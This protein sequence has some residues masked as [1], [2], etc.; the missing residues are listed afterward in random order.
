MDVFRAGYELA[1]L[2]E[3]V[4]GI[5]DGVDAIV[6]PSV[7]TVFTVEEVVAE[8]LASNATLGRYTDFV[9]TQ[10]PTGIPLAAA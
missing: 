1:D 6:A 7:P 5:W 9:S 4:D 2:R 8:P 3:E 10:P